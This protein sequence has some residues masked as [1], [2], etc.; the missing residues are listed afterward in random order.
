MAIT[1]F[2]D[3]AKLERMTAIRKALILQMPPLS[4]ADQLW[5]FQQAFGETLETQKRC[6]SC[7]GVGTY[8]FQPC[9]SCNGDGVYGSELEHE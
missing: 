3:K 2:S 9:I 8:C 7:N 4:H 1:V 5:L 6:Q